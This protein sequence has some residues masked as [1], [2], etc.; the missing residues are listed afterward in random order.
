M[1][2][3]FFSQKYFKLKISIRNA[4]IINW[5]ANGSRIDLDS[6]TRV[7]RQSF[8]IEYK[9]YRS[10]IKGPCNGIYDAV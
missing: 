7:T 9:R 2:I 4:F 3:K 8:A 5:I 10:N 6:Q 1:S